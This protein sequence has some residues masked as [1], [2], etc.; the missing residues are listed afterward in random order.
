MLSYIASNS[1]AELIKSICD[2]KNIT[3]LNHNVEELDFLEYIKQTKVNFNLIKFFI[4]DLSQIKNTEDEI[5]NSIRYFKELYLNT[6]VIIIAR[7]YD[8]QNKIL[9]SLYEN[10]IFNLI[11]DEEDLII[12]IEIKKCLSLE[13]LQEKDVKRFKKVEEV[14]TKKK[15]KKQKKA[16][17]KDEKKEKIKQE[18]EKE[19]I[20]TQQINSVYF[21][22]ILLEAITRLIKFISYVLV[23]SLTSIG[24][25]ILLNSELR[26]LVFQILGLK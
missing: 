16:L 21:F 6:R 18:N 4:I 17:V 25:T 26:E 23:F 13:G 11:N 10:K 12:Q 5:I 20:Q 1:T 24:L 9:T 14:Q 8:N 22:A 19:N 7:G 3:I 2:E 15:S